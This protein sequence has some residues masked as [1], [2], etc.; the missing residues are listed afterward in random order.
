MTLGALGVVFGDIGTSPLYAMQTVFTIDDR[1][2]RPDAT[3]VYG[4]I[5]LVFWAV[6]LIVSIKYVTLIMRADNHGE[7]GIMALIALVRG[8][9]VPPPGG[10]ARARRAR[11]LRRLAVLRR[12]D[13]HARHLGAVGGRGPGGGGARA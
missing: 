11:H 9:R 8:V 7:G 13:D 2:V 10:E 1:A 4:V 12:R 3:G 5:S 6:T